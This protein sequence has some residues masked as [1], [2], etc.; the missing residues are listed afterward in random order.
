MVRY[1]D[2]FYGVLG[3]TVHEVTSPLDHDRDYLAAV[4]RCRA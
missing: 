3:G 1:A 4:R 2:R